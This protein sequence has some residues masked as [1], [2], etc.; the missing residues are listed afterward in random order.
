MSQDPIQTAIVKRG[1]SSRGFL[2]PSGREYQALWFAL[3][4]L[5][6]N[7]LVLVPADRGGSTDLVTRA[8]AIIGDQLSIMPVTSVL[9]RPNHYKLAMQIAVGA[10]GTAWA[11]E[12]RASPR[13]GRF[14][15]AIESVIDEPLGVGVCQGADATVI[16]VEMGR[17]RLASVRRTAELIGRDKIVGTFVVD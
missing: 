13:A 3:A 16:C 15:I 11:D 4:K 8:L 6:W 1:D 7:S 12:E 14:L 10:S 9:A 5:A 17:S 2:D